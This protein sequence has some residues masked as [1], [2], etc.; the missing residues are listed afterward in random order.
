MNT[1][2]FPINYLKSIWTPI[3]AFENRRQL[4]W[5]QM[6]VIFLLLTFFMIIPVYTHYQHIQYFSIRDFYPGIDKLID[7]EMV[8]VLK[9]TDYINGEIHPPESNYLKANNQGVIGVGDLRN[10]A[11]DLEEADTFLLFDTDYFVIGDEQGN[12]ETINYT[13]DFSLSGVENGEDVLYELSRQYTTQNRDSIVNSFTLVI[14]LFILVASLFIVFI[15]AY[16]LTLMKDFTRSSIHT[17]KE[18]VNLILNSLGI[19]TL[20]AFFFGFYRFNIVTMVAIQIIG[21]ILML[22]VLFKQT[23][24]QDESDRVEYFS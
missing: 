1:S 18:A 11:D 5:P 22:F 6:I 2:I 17:Y 15:Y 9:Q 3:K 16:L 8:S 24:F 12:V 23:K 7:E 10:K 4:S 21:L 20:L 13:E 19:P 14:Y